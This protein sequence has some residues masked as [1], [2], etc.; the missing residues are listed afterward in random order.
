MLFGGLAA[1]S[2]AKATSSKVIVESEVFRLFPS[3]GFPWL[4]TKT[5]DDIVMDAESLAELVSDRELPPYH[6]WE[7][8]TP[9]K[10]NS[11]MNRLASLLREEGLT[12]GE[13]RIISLAAGS[14]HDRLFLLRPKA[15]RVAKSLNLNP[16]PPLVAATE[17]LKKGVIDANEF[18]WL[19][20]QLTNGTSDK[21]GD[22]IWRR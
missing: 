11:P 3:M 18:T 8:I 21:G 5:Y 17:A 2:A 14:H 4:L 9:L 15:R 13:S 7:L 20:W 10:K 19:S 22:A 12:K 6:K 16:S 1:L